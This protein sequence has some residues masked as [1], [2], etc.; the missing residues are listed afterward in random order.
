MIGIVYLLC[1]ATSFLGFVMLLRGYRRS[2]VR[3]LFWSSLC[4]LGLTLENVMLWVDLIT[5]PNIDLSVIR[6]LLGLG[7]LTLLLFGLIWDSK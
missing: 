2:G 5:G 7:G 6:R 4:F 1:A 3:L